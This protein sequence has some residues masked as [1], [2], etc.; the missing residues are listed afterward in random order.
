MVVSRSV[1][2]VVLMSSKSLPS[3]RSLPR[4]LSLVAYASSRW[5]SSFSSGPAAAAVPWL[6]LPTAETR[7]R[8]GFPRG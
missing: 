1:P 8:A 4:G 7:G 5:P 3:D 2:V 6:L